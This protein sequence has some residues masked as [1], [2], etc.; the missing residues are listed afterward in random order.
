MKR[1]AIFGGGFNPP[2]THHKALIP[3]MLK[4]F[5][6]IAVVPSG[7]GRPDKPD[8][9]ETGARDRLAMVHLDYDDISTR[10]LIDGTD[11]TDGIYTRTWDLQE[12]Y[13]QFGEVWYVIGS[14]QIIG[15]ALGQSPIH[16]WYRGPEVW[17]KLNFAVFRR[18]GHPYSEADL[19][20]HHE[21]YDEQMAGSSSEIRRRIA[22]GE[23]ISGLVSLR[24]E[25]YIRS[26]GL[27]CPH[28]PVTPT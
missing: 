21:K 25:G 2:G 6:F 14:D 12:R 27:Y 17:Q 11:L 23:S 22:A 18:K 1:I 5:D 8:I 16:G 28:V 13:A 15:G 4:H 26:H 10:I 3:I 19:P 20:P 7:D 9:G 24:V